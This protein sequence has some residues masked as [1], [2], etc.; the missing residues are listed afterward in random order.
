VLRT[1]SSFGLR[2]VVWGCCR[3]MTKTGYAG[4]G[5]CLHSDVNLHQKTADLLDGISHQKNKELE[6]EDTQTG[7]WRDWNLQRRTESSKGPRRKRKRR[8][9]CSC[10]RGSNG[11]THLRI[12]ASKGDARRSLVRPSIA[13]KGEVRRPILCCYGQGKEIVALQ[14]GRRPGMTTD[15]PFG[16][17]EARKGALKLARSKV[18]VTL[19]APTNTS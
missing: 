5:K 7:N 3:R 2:V 9:S 15:C 14:G 16:G 13:A 11:R 10:R 17:V 19:T 18:K 8:C 6:K 1:A 12:G 4:K